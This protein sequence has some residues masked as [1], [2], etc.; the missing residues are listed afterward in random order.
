MAVYFVTLLNY[1]M[2]VYM[3]VYI[4]KRYFIHLV[5]LISPRVGSLTIQKKKPHGRLFAL[6]KLCEILFFPDKNKKKSNIT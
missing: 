2:H 5:H 3:C 1:Q 4:Y 6:I